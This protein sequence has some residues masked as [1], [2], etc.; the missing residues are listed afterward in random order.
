MI[1]FKREPLTRALW[2]EAMP[3]IQKHWH[4]VAFYEDIPLNPDWP[5]Y[6]SANAAGHVVVFT[7]RTELCTVRSGPMPT[8]Q[9]QDLNCGVKP[10]IGTYTQECFLVGY[11]LYFVKHAPHYAG[12]L[13]ASQDVIY[14]H[15]SVRGKTGK[16]FIEYADAQL[17]LLGVQLVFQHAKVD[18][19]ALGRVLER[20]GYEKQDV[21]YSRRLD[22]VEDGKL[23]LR[24]SMAAVFNDKDM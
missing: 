17:A 14:L 12:S 18:H 3:L 21:V 11:A 9:R 16:R 22:R 5:L 15:P 24:E 8:A 20:I 2:D 1:Q 7:A 10:V 4:E 6:E 23:R 19:P 13:Q